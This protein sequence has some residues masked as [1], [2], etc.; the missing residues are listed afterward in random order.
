MSYGHASKLLEDGSTD[1]LAELRVA[2]RQLGRWA[3]LNPGL[4]S[5]YRDFEAC[6]RDLGRCKIAKVE[7]T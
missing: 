5:L 6:L 3:A 4:V 7:D 2:V 1:E